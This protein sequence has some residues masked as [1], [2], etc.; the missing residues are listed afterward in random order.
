MSGVLGIVPRMLAVNAGVYVSGA[1]LFVYNAGTT[2]KRAIYTTSALSAPHLNPLVADSNGRFAAFWV[3]PSGGAY[4][5]VLASSSDS[6]PP[7]SPFW[8]DDN[9]PGQ[10]P[11]EALP[12][13]TGTIV[14]SSFTGT[15]TGY[16]TPPTGTVKYRIIANAA[17]TGKICRLY[18]E[19]SISGTSNADTMTMTGLPAA[20][21]PS[22]AARG[23]CQLADNS[24]SVVGE[25]Q[26]AAAGTTITFACDT[27]FSV[28]GFTT[29]NTKGL[30][31]GWQ[32]EYAL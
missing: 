6:D 13:S 4:K 8:T 20:C 10:I 1:K 15:L 31:A 16:A 17:G 3:D 7:T 25:W 19:A 29:S 24:G 26:I 30:S 9:I 2:T 22:V 23:V 32:I 5:L 11:A 21:T 18:I 14:E 27:P 28:T 12:S